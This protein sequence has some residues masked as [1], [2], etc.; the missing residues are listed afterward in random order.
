MKQPPFQA[1]VFRRIRRN[2]SASPWLHLT[3]TASI[4]FAL[5][6]VGIFFL[7]FINIG[8]SLKQWQ[9]NV[10]IIAY[11]NDDAPVDRMM[12][13]KRKLA[14][15]PEV[16]RVKLISKAQA[17]ADLKKQ[18]PGRTSLLEGLDTNPLPASLIITLRNRPNHWR[19]VAALANRIASETGID[20]VEYAQAWIRRFSGILSFF[21]WATI[22]MCV[23]IVASTIFICTNTIRLTLYARQQEVEIMRLVGAT[24]R[25]IAMPFYIQNIAQGLLAGVLALGALLAIQALAIRGIQHHD[26]IMGAVDIRFI[27]WPSVLALLS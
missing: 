1:Y 16:A 26:I 25:F 5:V 22:V 6:V 21:R 15:F 23:L 24:D 14:D 8:H 19:S 2:L 18:L 9:G 11:L 20:G 7:L 27:A 10:Q 12:A 13:L 4:M 3:A 17:L